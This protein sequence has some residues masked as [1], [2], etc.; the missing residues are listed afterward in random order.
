VT[1]PAQ[2][3][4]STNTRRLHG[5]ILAIAWGAAV[6]LGVVV[7]GFCAYEI[8]WKISRLGADA[9][10]LRKIVDELSKIEAE[11]VTAADRLRAVDLT[12]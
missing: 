8:K 7:L 6:V 10:R 1:T 12:R 4:Q 3:S 11:L 9:A 2:L 5:V